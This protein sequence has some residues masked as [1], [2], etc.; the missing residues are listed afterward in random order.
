MMGVVGQIGIAGAFD[1]G[2]LGFPAFYFN[3]DRYISAGLAQ[4]IHHQQIDGGRFIFIHDPIRGAQ[5][6]VSIATGIIGGGPAG[7]VLAA[8][9]P[10]RA[11]NNQPAV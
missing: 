7:N 8:I 5:P 9:I 6:H 3:L 1:P 2:G 10:D 11:F 4:G